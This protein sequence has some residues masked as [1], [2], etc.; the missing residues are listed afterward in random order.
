MIKTVQELA[1]TV[2]AFSIVFS[3]AFGFIS[4]VWGDDIQSYKQIPSVLVKYGTVLDNY[5][6]E[7]S[8]MRQDINSIRPTPQVVEYNLLASQVSGPCNYKQPC[9]VKFRLRRTHEGATCSVPS[10]NYK[11]RN[12]FGLEYPVTVNDYEVVK[13]GEDWLNIS[14][15]FNIPKE[16]QLGLSEFF[17]ELEY[18]DCGFSESKIQENS[19]NLRFE[20]NEIHPD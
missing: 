4:Y 8:R 18:N 9:Y 16:V 12:H 17:V 20:V 6:R 5:G 11:V 10:A 1:K 7:L 15:S 13:V 19:P 3:A 2:T 14:Y